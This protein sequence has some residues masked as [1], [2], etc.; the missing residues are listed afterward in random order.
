MSVCIFPHIQPVLSTV[1]PHNRVEVAALKFTIKYHVFA[2][3]VPLLSCVVTAAYVQFCLFL[4]GYLWLSWSRSK[5]S[6]E[7]S[8]GKRLCPAL[9]RLGCLHLALL[10][11]KWALENTIFPLCAHPHSCAL[12]APAAFCLF[13][14]LK[15]PRCNPLSS[16]FFYNAWSR[17]W[18]RLKW[19]L[20]LP[21]WRITRRL[22]YSGWWTGWC[23]SPNNSSDSYI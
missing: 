17:G 9:C 4:W 21:S 6:W 13:F 7:R 3:I 10:C 19:A 5:Y 22:R 12:T 18:K 8:R 11:T 15:P 20:L 16:P 23:C 2:S 1:D 14:R